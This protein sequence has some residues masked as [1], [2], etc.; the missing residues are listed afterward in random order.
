M[1]AGF[2][3]SVKMLG[4]QIIDGVLVRKCGYQLREIMIFGF[5]QGGMAGLAV[6]RELGDHTT[7]SAA[8]STL[9]GVVSVGASYPLSVGKI[10]SNKKN[11]TPVLLVSG[12]DS[13]TVSDNAAKDVFEFVQVHRYARKGDTM[14]RN[15]VEMLPIMQFF[16]AHLRSRQ[17]VPED[18]L[19]I[20]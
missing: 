7:S 8:G 11:G 13:L 12:R 4:E 9:S 17:G 16:A 2:S 20:S 15:R 18:S 3:R 14:P 5:G 1:D 6:A 10:A 19:E